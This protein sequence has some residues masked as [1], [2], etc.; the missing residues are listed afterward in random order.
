MGTKH[1]LRVRL[2]IIAGALLLAG[3]TATVVR[4]QDAKA[5]YAKSCAMCHGP[6]GQGDGPA[7]KMMKPPPGPFSTT[8]QA[9]SEADIAKLLKEGGKAVGK[10]HP[11]FGGQWSDE[12]I[13]GLSEFVK[14]ELS[15]K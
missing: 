1:G 11:A 13:K 7:G 6:T 2:P 9:M 15:A 12:E 5:I 10:T 4:A 8:A 3:T 14:R